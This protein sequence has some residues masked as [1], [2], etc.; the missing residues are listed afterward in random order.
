[1]TFLEAIKAI[2]YF[3]KSGFKIEANDRTFCVIHIETGRRKAFYS[4]EEA[5]CWVQ[6]FVEAKGV[7][8]SLCRI[9]ETTV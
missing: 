9:T 7:Y 4:K 2:R 3:E 1:M 6:G 5:I 8:E